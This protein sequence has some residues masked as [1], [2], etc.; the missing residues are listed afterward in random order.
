MSAFWSGTNCHT[1]VHELGHDQPKTLKDLLDI[2]TRHASGE[3]VVWAVFFKISGQA[4]P[5]CGRAVPPNE[6]NKRRK[7][8]QQKS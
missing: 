3:E 8:E 2:A 4:T 6:I 7:E 5:Y 1:L